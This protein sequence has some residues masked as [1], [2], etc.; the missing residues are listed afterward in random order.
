MV[1]DG[2]RCEVHLDV[3][4]RDFGRYSSLSEALDSPRCFL[5]L[6]CNAG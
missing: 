5:L 4:C 1:V 6:C 3:K 2:T